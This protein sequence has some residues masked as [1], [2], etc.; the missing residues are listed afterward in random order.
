MSLTYKK[1]ALEDIDLL[2]ETRV[3]ILRAANGLSRDADMGEIKKRS[4][5][6][7]KKALRDGTHIA[8][9]A[10]DADRF[11][12]AGGVSFYQVMPTYHNPSGQKAYIMNIYTAPEYRRKAT[13]MGRPLYE[14]YGFIKMNDEMELPN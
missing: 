2:T 3:E 7:Y 9:L 6:Y 10:F 8:Y 5:E 12:G 11:A 13:A 14:K 4:C 1:A